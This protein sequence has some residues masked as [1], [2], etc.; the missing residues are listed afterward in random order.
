[1]TFQI[2]MFFNSYIDISGV[3]FLFIS[4]GYYLNLDIFFLRIFIF[5]IFL[6]SCHKTR[7]RRIFIFF[8][9]FLFVQRRHYIIIIMQCKCVHVRILYRYHNNN[10]QAALHS[11]TRALYRCGYQM[12]IQ[13]AITGIK[14][15]V[16]NIIHIHDNTIVRGNVHG[17]HVQD[18]AVLLLFA[19]SRLSST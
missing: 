8:L 11:I 1:M 10:V 6:S 4:I 2:Y 14:C 15:H 18:A 9:V 19:V 17:N 3:L 7:A 5:R 16:H 13:A 12:H